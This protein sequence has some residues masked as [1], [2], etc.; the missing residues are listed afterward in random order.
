MTPAI[1][2]A[3]ARTTR[4]SAQLFAAWLDEDK[5]AI[6]SL[7]REALLSGG[8]LTDIVCSLLS[9]GACLIE[10]AAADDELD[11]RLDGLLGE[12]LIAEALTD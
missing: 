9:V 2:N 1:D 5:A 3:M 10:A 11:D 4:R 6:G 12:A 7:M 8:D